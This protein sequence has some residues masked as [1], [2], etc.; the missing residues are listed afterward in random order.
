[1]EHAMKINKPVTQRIRNNSPLTAKISSGGSSGTNSKGAI[2][3]I[4]QLSNVNNNQSNASNGLSNNTRIGTS[5]SF[6]A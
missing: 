3:I 6:Y 4:N 5:F 2:N 1:M